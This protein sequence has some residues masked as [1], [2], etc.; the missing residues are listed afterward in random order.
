[1]RLPDGTEIPATIT[2]IDPGGEPTGDGDETTSATAIVEFADQAA[3]ADVGLRSVKVT[4][5]ARR[6]RRRARGAR[7][8][9]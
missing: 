1:M 8:P 2:T 6:G 5:A 4:I 7:S 9:R 3:V